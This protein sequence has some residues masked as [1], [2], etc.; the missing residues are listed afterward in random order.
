MVAVVVGDMDSSW[1]VGEVQGCGRHNV[2]KQ[3]KTTGLALPGADSLD[4]SLTGIERR[5]RRAKR[6]L[7][8]CGR[9]RG[10]GSKHDGPDD[11]IFSRR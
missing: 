4:G 8:H 11:K 7:A 5:G 6:G 3:R 10:M 2:G 1:R 9:R